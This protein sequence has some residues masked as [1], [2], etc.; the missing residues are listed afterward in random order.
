MSVHILPSGIVRPPWAVV[1]VIIILIKE[2]LTAISSLETT[3][4]SLL[5]ISTSLLAKSTS[6]PISAPH[7]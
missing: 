7:G 2:R 5:T 6:L 4:S 3:S 1:I